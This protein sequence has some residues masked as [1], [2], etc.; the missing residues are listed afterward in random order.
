MRRSESQKFLQISLSAERKTKKSAQLRIE[1]KGEDS[2]AERMRGEKTLKHLE[3]NGMKKRK[4]TKC[5]EIT[6]W[7][8]PMQTSKK[9]LEL[10][11]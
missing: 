4:L 2:S 11:R 1:D 6:P 5:K 10:L 8:L 3:T 7:K 9:S